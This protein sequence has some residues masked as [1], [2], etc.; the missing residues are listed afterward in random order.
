MKT[1]KRLSV[2]VGITTCYG[3]ESIL[4]TVKSIRASKGI[5]NF[6]FIIVADRVPISQ[7]IKKVLHKYNVELIENKTEASQIVKQKQILK[8]TKSDVII[9]TQDD[10]LYDQY[11]LARIVEA[12]EKNPKITMVSVR[13]Q[14]VQ[15]TNFFESILNVGTNIN[16]R[17][18]RMWKR[19]DNYLSVI[20]RC[21]GFR[22]AFMKKNF[23]LPE[24]IATTDAYY[25]FENKR[26]K[27]KYQ[28]LPD[29]PVYFKNPQ[30][31]TEH[32]RKSSRFQYSQFEMS[33]YFSDIEK[34]Y[35]K[36]KSIIFLAMFLEFFPHPV[37]FILY[38][39]VF[40]FT[41]FKKL[42]PSYVLNA[43]WEVDTSTKKVFR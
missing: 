13:N 26:N 5:G 18:A 7:R 32:M 8:M 14:P 20:G 16:N 38:L 41:R 37:L 24:S 36:P 1:A 10:V 29:V 42:T 28:F 27:G 22:T 17:I 39:G 30:N 2:T 19:G 12:F 25:Y 34:E 35:I 11:G 31:L 4:D 15:A 33:K 43:V 9:M 3:D 23:R 21:M 6:R 40:I